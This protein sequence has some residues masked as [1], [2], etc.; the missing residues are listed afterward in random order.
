MNVLGIDP[1][2]GGGLAV[3]Y[4]DRS[5]EAWPMPQTELDLW[6]LL[7]RF[8][9]PSEK[10]T[11]IKAYL[12][13][14]SSAPGMGSTGAFSFGSNFGAIRMGL[15][16]AR[17]PFEMVS[18][19]VW[20]KGYAL[21]PLPKVPPAP[22]KRATA[23]EVDGWKKAKQARNKAQREK[24]NALKARAQELW[25]SIRITHAIADALLIAEWGRRKEV[26]E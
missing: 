16:A 26:H 9:Q 20:Q 4:A 24:K 22:G 23:D 1:G 11:W 10:G 19:H 7:R 5:V 12:E 15:A 25:P 8:K 21:P 18:P 13:R 17:I 2:Q 14:V 6:E 3:V